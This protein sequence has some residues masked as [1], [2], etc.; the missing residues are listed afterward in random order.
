MTESVERHVFIVTYGCH[1][2]SD[3]DPILSTE[4]QDIGLFSASEIA[5][6]RMPDGYRRSISAWLT[7]PARTHR[8]APG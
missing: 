4:H 7:H 8:A 6:L 1:P 5:R 3:A 2:Q